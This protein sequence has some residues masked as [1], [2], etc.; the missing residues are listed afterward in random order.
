MVEFQDGMN[1]YITRLENNREESFIW[2]W[3]R[4]SVFHYLLD[5]FEYK[6]IETDQ[7]AS[8]YKVDGSRQLD[9]ANYKF[10]VGLSMRVYENAVNLGLEPEYIKVYERALITF[11]LDEISFKEL[12]NITLSAS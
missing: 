11:L 8:V 3:T 1:Q 10:V 9:E 4:R 12:K 5:Y 7:I 2:D 6:G